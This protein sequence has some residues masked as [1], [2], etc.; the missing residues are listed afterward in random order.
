MEPDKIK[1]HLKALLLSFYIWSW[2][3]VWQYHKSYYALMNKKALLLPK[4]VWGVYDNKG[5]GSIDENQGGSIIYLT[6]CSWSS[7]WGFSLD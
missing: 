6:P 2:K 3:C 1:K 5:F 7:H 4:L